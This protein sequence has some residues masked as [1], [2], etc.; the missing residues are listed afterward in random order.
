MHA[1][2]LIKILALM[3]MPATVAD[4]Y[5]WVFHMYSLGEMPA[6]IIITD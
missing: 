2:M 1:L 3:G 4:A 5:F 6:G